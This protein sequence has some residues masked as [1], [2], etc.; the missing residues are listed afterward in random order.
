MTTV[1]ADD[2]S[3][4]NTKSFDPSGMLQIEL[5][6]ILEAGKR[7]PTVLLGNIGIGSVSFAL[8]W[9]EVPQ[10]LLIEV[11][12][13]FILSMLLRIFLF[14]HY[15]NVDSSSVQDWQFYFIGAS[16]L[17]GLVWGSIGLLFEVYGNHLHSFQAFILGGMAAGGVVTNSS[18]RLNYLFYILPMLVPSILYYFSN[19]SSEHIWMGLMYILF[20][21]IMIGS[22]INFRQIL[23]EKM[24]LLYEAKKVND[25]LLQIQLKLQVLTQNM[26]E[27]QSIAHVGNWE[28]NMKDNSLFWS[29]EI[30]RIFGLTPQSFAAT[31]DGF[32]NTVYPDDREII[33]KVIEK[34]VTENIPYTV[35]HR[36]VLPD[37]AIRIVQEKGQVY[38]NSDGENERM[39]GTVQDITEQEMKKKELLLQSSILDAISDAIFVHPLN[40]NFVYVNESATLTRGF[41]KGEFYKMGVADLDVPM[42]INDEEYENR[43]Q[44]IESQIKQTGSAV[45]EVEHRRKQGVPIP[46]EVKSRLIHI[47]DKDYIISIARDISERQ[48][49]QRSLEE[50]ESKYRSLVENSLVGVYISDIYGNMHYVNDAI[51]RMMEYESNDELMR[52]S[53]VYGYQDVNDRAKLIEM[54]KEKGHVSNYQLNLITKKNSPITV[55]LSASFD[56]HRL[57]GTMIDVTSEIRTRN[58]LQRMSTIVEQ[59]DDLVVVTNRA[60]IVEYVNEA[61]IKQT[62]Y[63]REEIYG[64]KTNL[65]RSGEH[66]QSFYQKLWETILS[67]EVYRDRIINRKKNGERYYEQKTITPLKDK[68]NKVVGFVSSAKDVTYNVHIE[69]ELEKMARTDSLTGLYN[70]YSFEELYE[71]EIERAKRYLNA[72]SVIM[73]DIDHFKRIND[74]YGHAVGDKVLKQLATTVQLVIRKSDIF[75]RVGGEEFVIL[76]P[77]TDTEQAKL[78]ANKIRQE[79]EAARFEEAG[80]LTSSFG[81]AQYVIGEDK[82]N[83]LKRADDAL[84]CAKKHGRNRVEWK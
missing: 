84:Y 12:I 69:Q 24:R 36:I 82:E 70:R 35:K 2:K 51:V 5:E 23:F 67:G 8:L 66:D 62:G 38:Q 71:K 58:E 49:I 34:T 42:A 72:L 16:F 21:V 14:R 48:R 75:A 40:G 25:E 68:N 79:I 65:L 22:S 37:G 80:K 18:I 45:F 64:K 54:L 13:L 32:I 7:I 61:F 43:I 55:L 81:V 76:C 73:L 53:T 63:T 52:Q 41:S 47:D 30:Y 29:D 11:S 83:L 6:H 59:I 33:E 39:V 44:K 20:L 4:D 31:Y 3:K 1:S 50:S 26:V 19:P 60:G 77:E 17:S 15:K 57:S 78:L 28:W 46:V 74:T 9:G 27:A 56:G 10:N